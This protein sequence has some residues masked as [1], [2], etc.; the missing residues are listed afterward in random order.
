MAAG[1][2]FCRMSCFEVGVAGRDLV[3]DGDPEV[4]AVTGLAE[5]YC[6]FPIMSSFSISCS[7]R[8]EMVAVRVFTSKL[9]IVIF[10]LNGRILTFYLLTEILTFY[11]LTEI[12]ASLCKLNFFLIDLD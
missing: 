1:E 3:E 11:L 6:N 10:S 2:A 12:L 9:D 4:E 5:E 7:L 8:R